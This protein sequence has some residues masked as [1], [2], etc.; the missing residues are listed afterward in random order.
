[1]SISTTRFPTRW[2]LYSGSGGYYA[3]NSQSGKVEVTGSVYATVKN[4][5]IGGLN[6]SI[7]DATI[8]TIEGYSAGTKVMFINMS[9]S[10][11]SGSTLQVANISGSQMNLTGTLT[12]N[13]AISGSS[14]TGVSGSAGSQGAAGN[15]GAYTYVVR[16]NAG[17]Y[18][19]YNGATGAK[20][21]SNVNFAA[22]MTSVLGAISSGNGSIYFRAAT[23]SLDSNISNSSLDNISLIGEK[24]TIFQA[25]ASITGGMIRYEGTSGSHIQGGKVKGITLN[26]N[27]NASGIVLKWVDYADIDE[28]I[29]YGTKHVSGSFANAIEILGTTGSTCLRVNVHDCYVYDTYYAGIVYSY[30]QFCNIYDNKAKD[31]CQI[32]PGGGAIQCDSQCSDMSITNNVISGDTWNDGI[33]VGNSSYINYRFKVNNNIINLNEQQ[34]NTTS[35]IKTY[36]VDSE[37]NDNRITLSGNVSGSTC[38]HN[39]GAN[40]LF[41][42]NY[43]VGGYYGFQDQSTYYQTGSSIIKGNTFSGSFLR[44]IYSLQRGNEYDDNTICG[45]T[46]SATADAF[47]LVTGHYA[48]VNGLVIKDWYNGTNPTWYVGM[49]ITAKYATFQNIILDNCNIGISEASGCA[50]NHY[51]GGTIQNLATGIYITSTGSRVANFKFITGSVTTGINVSAGSS[52]SIIFGCDFY[53]ITTDIT[54]GGSRTLKNCYVTKAGAYTA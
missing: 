34:I 3:V 10:Q 15:M 20:D 11:V 13:G 36:C 30:S 45:S 22:L 40:N 51:N 31:C 46:G 29:V 25:T 1:M 49:N 27:N 39:W 18:E 42:G 21:F 2:I 24:G 48:K 44:G 43:C 52:G 16:N 37:F 7:Y 6:G 4:S 53:G 5:V 47:T 54:D 28:C 12:V 32:Y 8:D 26:C 19:A 33:Y 50:F 38:L 23:Y 35:G 9:G 17:T 41:E 14:Y